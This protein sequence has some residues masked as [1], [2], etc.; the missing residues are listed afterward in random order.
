M[1][2]PTPNNSNPTPSPNSTSASLS[3]KQTLPIPKTGHSS[4]PAAR[5]KSFVRKILLASPAFP[6]LYADVVISSAP[7]SKEAKILAR[8]YKK[9]VDRINHQTNHERTSTQMSN[10]KSCTH[11]KVTGVR[12]GSP[13]LRGE[14]FCYFHQRMLRT[15][16]GPPASRV[17]H[18]ALLEDEESIQA[19]LIEVV[20]AL[21]RGTIELKRAELILRALNTAVRNIR[22]VHFGLHASDMV[23][24]VPTYPA[25]PDVEVEEAARTE[26]ARQADRAEIARIRAAHEVP[27]NVGTAHVAA[28]H[29]A[30]AQVATAHVGTAAPGCPGGP[31]VPGRSAVAPKPAQI[32]PAKATDRKPPVSVKEP[33]APKERKTTAHRVS[34]G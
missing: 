10:P 33:E 34:G 6:R 7:N 11:I 28:A 22:R 9:I 20:N 31:E 29:A 21:L 13:A 3:P 14:Q 2:E 23:K 15:V 4:T 19:S 1:H 27:A 8:N 24:E 12:C 16:S 32:P 17:H 30:S 26:A 25:V 18:A 5:V